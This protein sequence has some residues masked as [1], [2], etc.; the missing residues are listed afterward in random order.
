MF[1]YPLLAAVFKISRGWERDIKRDLHNHKRT[2]SDTAN[3][4]HY[5]R[6]PKLTDTGYGLRYHVFWKIRY[7]CIVLEP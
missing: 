6:A 7:H 4:Y 5:I 1:T 2:L 3:M